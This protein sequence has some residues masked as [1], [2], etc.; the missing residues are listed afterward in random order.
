MLFYLSLTPIQARI[1]RDVEVRVFTMA[2]SK[3]EVGASPESFRSGNL[4][5]PRFSEKLTQFLNWQLRVVR[6]IDRR[7]FPFFLTRTT[8]S[9]MADAQ[10][11]FWTP[12]RTHE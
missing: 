6:A 12:A 11:F 7:R 4:R 2:G 1:Q 9:P 3:E 5:K 8:D 10:L